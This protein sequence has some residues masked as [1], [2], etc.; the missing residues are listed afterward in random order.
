MVELDPEDRYQL[1]KMQ[2]DTDK[3][4]LDLRRA[5]Q[6]LDRLM[7]ELEHK[8]GLIAEERTIDPATATVREPVA[9][10][11]RN[12]NGKGHPE[13]LIAAAAEEAAD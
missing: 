5:Q 7:L 8:Y 2:M 3:K 12:G 13:A 11:K 1:R 4:S 10:G 9:S 6:D